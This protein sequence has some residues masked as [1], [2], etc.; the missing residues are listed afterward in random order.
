M[1]TPLDGVRVLDL[2]RVL[3]GPF[4]TML[5]ADLGADVLK[6]E[7]A[8]G[9]DTRHFGPPFVGGESTYFLAI[10]RGKRSLVL[11]LKSPDGI[12]ELL[13]LAA[14]SD[15][16]VENFR[17]GVLDRLGI[18]AKTLRALNPRL[19]V[20]SL[21]GFGQTGLDEWVQ[22]PGYD[23]VIQALSGVMSLTGEA[24]GPPVKAGVSVGDL[25]GGLYLVQGVLAAL[26]ER[27]RTGRGRH[28]DVAL[29]DALVSLLGYQ[30]GQLFATGQ[31]PTR[32]GSRHPSICPFET[33]QAADGPF[34]LC[35][36]N[37]AQFR[38]LAAELGLDDEP[39][40]RT[41]PGRVE[42]H[43]ALLALLA[44][45]FRAA[46]V[47]AWIARLG[48]AG[49]PCAPVLSLDQALAHPQLAAR[50]MLRTLEH[51]TLGTLRAVSSPLVLDGEVCFAEL[52]PP[53]LGDHDL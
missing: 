37:D 13:R 48:A 46:P 28:V 30:A 33:V 3:A 22:A 45:R 19:I 16:L 53:K 18:G 34:V 38:A 32:L 43:D 4:A 10:N 29:L 6:I 51:P 11:D 7:Q 23:L 41:N 40:F 35:C 1:A 12:A 8:S 14:R 17:P 9:D 47:D 27:E 42:H 5:L 50:G 52:A 15:V 20:A 36:G 24:G 26:Y 44:E 2:T 21:S 39:R 31:A 49:V 25:V